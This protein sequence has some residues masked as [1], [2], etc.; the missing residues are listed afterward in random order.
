MVCETTSTATSRFNRLGMAF[1]AGLA[2]LCMHLGM[3]VAQEAQAVPGTI[4]TMTPPEGFALASDFA[5]FANAEKQG[6]FL[7][8]EFPPEAA[9]QLSGLFLDQETAAA[10][11]ATKGI[12]IE[13]REEFDNAD[14]ETIPLLRG[15]Q[16]A[17][18]VTLDKWMALYAG[19]KI[20]MI[21]FQIPQDNALDDEAMKAAFGSV[22]LGG[23]EG[24]EGDPRLAELPYSLN[25]VEPFRL[26]SVTDGT[27][28]LLTVGDKDVDPEATQ[29]QIIVT[30][31]ETNAPKSELKRIA[32]VV[33]NA[34]GDNVAIES[35]E[36][37]M[38]AGLDGLATKGTLE[39]N[40]VKKGFAHWVAYTEAGAPI[41]VLGTA[42]EDKYAE[43]SEAIEEIAGSVE[44]NE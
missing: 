43:L 5:G 36:E 39:E 26:A 21:T 34:I 20:V 11:F 6:S 27:G 10:Q 14:G 4:V 12:T 40:G 37:E 15:T 38:F 9:A 25:V 33:L 7:V 18:G 16:E 3:A 17:N 42:A 35:Q 44:M 24:A 2:G 23:I 13:S 31:T 1:M 32:E 28:A 29:P 22:K 8:A 19:P 30:Y 41:Q